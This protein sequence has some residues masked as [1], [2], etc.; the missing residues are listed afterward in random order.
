M[1]TDF[2]FDGGHSPRPY[3]RRYD[4]DWLR[5]FAFGMLILYHVGMFYVTWD[6]HV[7]S[8]YASHLVE[9]AMAMVNPWRL[10]LLF[11]ISGIA[12]RFATD[13]TRLRHFLPERLMRLFLPLVFGMAVV[14]MPQAYA[15]L[16]FKGEIEPGLLGFYPDYLS[17]GDF[18]IIV[19]TWNHLWYVAY[20]LVYTVLAAA[21]L[22]LLRRFADG[23]AARFFVWLDGGIGVAAAARAGA[24]VPRLPPDARPVLPDNAHPL[25]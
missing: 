20:V 10:A 21:A 25:G 15:E 24:S 9:P 2:S 11:L 4:L 22:P 23:P 18:S 6:W 14:V 8:R 16:R 1:A 17:F 19:P 3:T 13:K 12:I 7:K 5:V